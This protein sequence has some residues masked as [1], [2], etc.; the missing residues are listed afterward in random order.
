MVG[1]LFQQR[2]KSMTFRAG[3][4]R[5]DQVSSY[6]VLSCWHFQRLVGQL[7]LQAVWESGSS[8]QR[9][10]LIGAL[11][12]RCCLN[13]DPCYVHRRQGGYLCW[14][15]MLYH[16]LKLWVAELLS[17]PWCYLLAVWCAWP[18]CDCPSLCWRSR[19]RSCS[20][21]IQAD[22]YRLLSWLLSQVT[23]VAHMAGNR[24]RH[25]NLDQSDSFGHADLHSR[26]YTKSF[27]A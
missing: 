6:I 16:W 25:L 7:P 9:P 2:R 17:K 12:P 14:K 15:L 22:P 27:A 11:S 18:S 13:S 3:S 8:L 20:W 24:L 1:M 4:S 10:W 19:T 21:Q 26:P 5:F 23:L